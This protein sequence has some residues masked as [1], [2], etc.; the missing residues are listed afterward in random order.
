M[1][2]FS[3]AVLKYLTPH[4]KKI[5]QVLYYVFLLDVSYFQYFYTNVVMALS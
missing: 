1:A 4:V 3:A 2:I 5:Q